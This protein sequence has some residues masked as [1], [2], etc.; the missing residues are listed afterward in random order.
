MSVELIGG[1]FATLDMM[2]LLP[3][4]SSGFKVFVRCNVDPTVTRV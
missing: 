4:L 3:W 2:G 1:I